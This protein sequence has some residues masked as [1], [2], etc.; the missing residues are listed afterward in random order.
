MGGFKG[1]WGGGPRGTP[2]TFQNGSGAK[3]PKIFFGAKR[4]KEIFWARSARRKNFWAIFGSKLHEKACKCTFFC[5][6]HQKKLSPP[7]AKRR[8]KNFST[9]RREAPKE[10]FSVFSGGTPFVQRGGVPPGPPLSR[11]GGVPPGGPL[12]Q[13]GSPGGPPH[14]HY[15]ST[16]YSQPCPP[17]TT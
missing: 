13:G 16:S 6:L 8:R 9:F 14:L 5:H 11:G 17:P 4:R 7:G 1:R 15:F 12:P 10:K 3:R 2:P